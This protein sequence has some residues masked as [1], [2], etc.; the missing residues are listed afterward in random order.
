MAGHKKWNRHEKSKTTWVELYPKLA[1]K[2]QRV[3]RRP[4]SLAG[5]AS[6][7]KSLKG[8][9]LIVST[10]HQEEKT[11]IQLT[12]EERS[13]QALN[14]ATY[15]SGKIREA[16]EQAAD[17]YAKNPGSL[18]A[19]YVYAEMAGDYSDNRS[20]PKARR[21]ELLKMARR[22]IKEV[23]D[24]KNA[25]RYEFYQHVRNEWRSLTHKGLPTDFPKILPVPRDPARKYSP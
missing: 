25:R 9:N 14:R 19:K 17:F 1:K 10:S 18:F 22:L 11:P 15:N 5:P 23:Y 24:D 12:A 3:A 7:L 13:F 2:A 4:I 8:R 20:L 6:S 21:K 16:Y